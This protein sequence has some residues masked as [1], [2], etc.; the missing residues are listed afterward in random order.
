MASVGQRIKELRKINR[1]T[2]E[3]FAEMIGITSKHLGRIESGNTNFS[4]DVLKSMSKSFSI[5]SDYILFGE[6]TVESKAEKLTTIV[7]HMDAKKIIVVRDVLEY[8]SEI[9]DSMEFEEKKRN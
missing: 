5:S 3:E 9:C 2:Q 6:E 7:E 8:L 1:Y 4:V